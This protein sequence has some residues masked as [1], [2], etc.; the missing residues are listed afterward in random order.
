MTPSLINFLTSIVLGALLLS[1][2]GLVLI[3]ISKTDRIIRY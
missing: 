3:A 1:L 2:I